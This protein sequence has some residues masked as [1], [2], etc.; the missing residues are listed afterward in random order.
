MAVHRTSIPVSDALTPFLNV[1]LIPRI[2]LATVGFTWLGCVVRGFLPSF[3]PSFPS[4]L[5]SFLPLGFG[6]ARLHSAQLGFTL[7]SLARLHSASFGLASLC[8]AWL[9]FTRLHSAQ[10]GFAW[11]HSASLGLRKRSI[12][13]ACNVKSGRAYILNSCRE[14]SWAGQ[15]AA[16][17]TVLWVHRTMPF[18][19]DSGAASLAMSLQLS[20]LLGGGALHSAKKQIT[21]CK[22][23]RS[24]VTQCESVLVLE[25]EP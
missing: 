24:F 15:E 16:G 2:P 19:V 22:S 13:G 3:L 4:F 5:P 21:R 23:L 10:F 12:D 20:I 6:L 17:Q 9:G 25:I 11:L 8:T 1:C 18:I 14:R 7:L